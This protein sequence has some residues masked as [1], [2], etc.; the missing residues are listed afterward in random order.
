MPPFPAA[1]RDKPTYDEIYSPEFIAALAGDMG[2]ALTHETARD[3]RNGHH[4]AFTAFHAA[5]ARQSRHRSEGAENDLLARIGKLS[6]SLQIALVE[7]FDFDAASA[8]LAQQVRENPTS[9]TGRGGGSLSALLN[10]DRP[11]NPFFDLQ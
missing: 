10:A 4:E 11:D 6:E 9:F 1:Y 3:L 7:L 2:I 8:K 5:E